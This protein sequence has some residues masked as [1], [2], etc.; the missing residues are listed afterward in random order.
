MP[1]KVCSGR[2]SRA[3][4]RKGAAGELE[5][6]KLLAAHGFDCRRDGRLD[7]DLVHDCAG[8]H[9]EV[10]RAESLRLPE[11]TR[12]AETDAN[13]RVP[14]VVYRSSR[15]PWRAVLPFD[16]LCVLLAKGRA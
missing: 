6:A 4:R 9:F 15:E 11:W 8:W 14:V 1:T 2:V 12:Q 16:A 5:V 7:T 13:G 3:S 10:K